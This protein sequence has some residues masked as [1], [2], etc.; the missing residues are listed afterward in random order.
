MTDT[1]GSVPLTPGAPISVTFP[2]D[3]A[4]HRF[5]VGH[6][7]R[8]SLSPTYWPFAWPSPEPVTLEVA[9]GD[10]TFVTLPVRA[11]DDN[12]AQPAFAAPERAALP[13][14]ETIA[15]SERTLTRHA[16]TGEIRSTVVNDERSRLAATDL[17]FGERQ[18]NT[19]VLVDDDP[20]GAGLQYH[21]EHHLERGDWRIRVVVNTSVS[22]DAEAF[23]VT[24]ERD[25]YEGDVRVHALRRAVRVPR[26]G[27]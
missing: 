17:W 16:G 8:L 18:E 9:L 6:R 11:V 20:L 12:G 10:G 5:P 26:N 14:G 23:T 24:T 21:A 7:V 1:T 27:N 22:A 3:F 19:H 2:L 15:S 4:G 25:A 13:A